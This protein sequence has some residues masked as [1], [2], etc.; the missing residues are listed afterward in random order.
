[1]GNSQFLYHLRTAAGS[2]SERGTATEWH[3][4][5]DYGVFLLGE[6]GRPS[7]L[8]MFMPDSRT[9]WRVATELAELA[10][11]M[12]KRERELVERYGAGTDPEAPPQGGAYVDVPL[13]LLPPFPAAGYDYFLEPGEPQDQVPAAD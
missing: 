4:Q 8:T 5:D 7:D 1:M 2:D 12:D 11:A 10:A 3:L 13:P 9:A 6:G